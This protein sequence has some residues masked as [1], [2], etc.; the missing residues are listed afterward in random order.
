M[1]NCW[2]LDSV[3]TICLERSYMSPSLSSTSLPLQAQHLP[4]APHTPPSPNFKLNTPVPSSSCRETFTTSLW[5]QFCRL[6]NNTWAYLPERRGP[7][8]LCM[9]TLRMHTSPLLSPL[10]AGQITTW[11]T[12]NPAMCLWWR[13]SLWPQGLWGGGRRRLMRHCRA[14][15]PEDSAAGCPTAATNCHFTSS[16]LHFLTDPLSAPIT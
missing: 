9:L 7:W 15:L 5:I 14:A 3:H 6:S 1:L 2:S 4:A 10:W 16:L 11:F 13:G 8:T 12:S